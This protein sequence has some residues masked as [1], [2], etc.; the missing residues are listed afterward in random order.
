MA[1]MAKTSS[2]DT[3]QTSRKPGDQQ[4][5]AYSR[6]CLGT[7]QQIVYETIASYWTMRDQYTAACRV[8]EP[9]RRL[10]CGVEVNVG[11]DTLELGDFQDRII[12]DV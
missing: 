4:L 2:I 9:R 8:T 6:Q 12:V 11:K 3:N 5:T 10:V 7:L 1:E